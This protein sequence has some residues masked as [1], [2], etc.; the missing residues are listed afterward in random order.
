M[1]LGL[2]VNELATNAKKH[3]KSAIEVTFSARPDGQYEL[4]VLDRGPGLPENFSVKHPDKAGLGI[5]VVGSLARQL[6]GTFSASGN[7]AGRGACFKVVF[8]ALA[9]SEQ[10]ARG[11]AAF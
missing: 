7:P 8:P 5:K 11:S 9:M 4:C 1:A 10:V 2:I 3:G 6:Q